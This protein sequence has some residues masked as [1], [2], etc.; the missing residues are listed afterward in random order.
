MIE[1]VQKHSFV[2]FD[3]QNIRNN[4]SSPRNAHIGKVIVAFVQEERPDLNAFIDGI[5]LCVVFKRRYVCKIHSTSNTE[6]DKGR[7][8]NPIKVEHQIR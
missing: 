5:N 8:L 2:L 4:I 3:T 6:S 1:S 7:T